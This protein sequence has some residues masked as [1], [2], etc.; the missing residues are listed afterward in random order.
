MSVEIRMISENTGDVIVEKMSRRVD[1]GPLQVLKA[2]TSID[3]RER[4]CDKSWRGVVE[5][6]VHRFR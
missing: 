4:R 2:S 5:N 1:G 3:L 6:S